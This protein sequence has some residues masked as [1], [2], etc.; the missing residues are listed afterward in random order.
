MSKQHSTRQPA[1]GKP[2]K[3]RDDFPLTPHPAGYWCKKILG[4]L[5]YFGPRFDFTDHVAAAAA[6]GKALDEYNKQAEA[7]HAGRKPREQAEEGATVHE[8]VNRFLHHKDALVEAG[9]L[10]PRTKTDYK[11]ACDQIVAGFGKRR[12]LADLAPD[13]FEEL[14]ERMAKKW[15]PHRLGK[16]I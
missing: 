13:D 3:P 10:S 16:V 1:K 4:K 7:L 12:L 8:L 14:R 2:A 5:H 9:E 11:E 6:A 15:G